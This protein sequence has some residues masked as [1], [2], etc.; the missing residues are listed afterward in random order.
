MLDVHRAKGRQRERLMHDFTE[1]ELVRIENT[2]K[3][4]F[5][6]KRAA[7][8]VA[9]RIGP[10]IKNGELDP[11]RKNSVRFYVWRKGEN[12][13]GA[14]IPGEIKFRLLRDHHFL[15]F[16]LPT[17]I[18]EVCRG[19]AANELVA[20]QRQLRTEVGVTTRSN[21]LDISFGAATRNRNRLDV[22]RGFVACFLVRDKWNGRL[23]YRRKTLI[24]REVV[25]WVQRGR[26][27]IPVPLLTDVVQTGRFVPTGR[28]F[29]G[30]GVG[31]ATVG[32]VIT[33]R[34]N[35]PLGP[36]PMWGLVTVGHA[37]GSRSSSAVQIERDGFEACRGELMARSD[38]G[39]EGV[40]AAIIAVSRGSLVRSEIIPAQLGLNQLPQGLKELREEQLSALVSRAGISLR[41]GTPVRFSAT[42][43]LPSHRVKRLGVI[44]NVVLAV[45]QDN[46]FAPGT[47]G[48]FW[49]LDHRP[50]ALQ[51]AGN[52][53]RFDV[54]LAQSLE[55][56]FAWCRTVLKRNRGFIQESFRFVGVF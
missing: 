51:I 10:A 7:N 14:S 54:G 47:S 26:R 33:W 52:E 25:G 2:V 30:R 18:V 41:P 24:P 15:Q 46:A 8:I 4:R 40:D 42:R 28:L 49:Q 50:A 20:L 27:R 11:A 37:F 21:I 23:D 45:G 16:G 31:Q 9:I 34:E 1:S 53:N 6:I 5:G 29:G 36:T 44:N 13:A 35:L 39:S 17:D 32:L 12:L 38:V 55:S 22:N 48:S 19:L 43:V 56:T 3:R